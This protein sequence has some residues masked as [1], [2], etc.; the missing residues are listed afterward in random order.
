MYCVTIPPHDCVSCSAELGRV[1]YV[2]LVHKTYYATLLADIDDPIVWNTGLQAKNI[3]TY[4]CNGE[5]DGGTSKL[6]RG[7]GRAVE[8]LDYY[9]FR[10]KAV[11]PDYAVNF[12]HWN[13]LKGR[14]YYLIFCSENVMFVTQRAAV[15]V[16]SN[17]I[18]NDLKQE[19]NWNVEFRWVNDDSPL[20]YAITPDVFGCGWV[21]VAGEYRLLED[22]SYRLLEDGYKRLLQ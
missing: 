6:S 17:P 14:D 18:A 3:F 4:E 13:Y 5:F 2:A 10:V 8:T 22:G 16:P 12:N 15:I 20:E 19:V 1:R 21:Y 9:S 7:F 11:F